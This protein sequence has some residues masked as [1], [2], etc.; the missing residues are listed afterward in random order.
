MIS[1]LSSVDTDTLSLILVVDATGLTTPSKWTVLEKIVG[2]SLAGLFT[3]VAAVVAARFNAR[4]A[5]AR[6]AEERKQLDMSGRAA[7]YGKIRMSINDVLN[8]ARSDKS[9]ETYSKEWHLM[10]GFRESSATRLYRKLGS[11]LE[12]AVAKV[13]SGEINMEDLERVAWEETER[14]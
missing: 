2:G 9:R 3:I 1:T 8:G 4:S 10:R 11:S 13:R 6:E 5:A 14:S 12:Q 7:L